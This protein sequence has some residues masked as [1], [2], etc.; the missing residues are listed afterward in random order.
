MIE[1]LRSILEEFL[2]ISDLR[3]RVGRLES[4][5]ELFA[6]QLEDLG[7]YK[8]MTKRELIE[9]RGTIKTIHK[10]LEK[11][12]DSKGHD[13]EFERAKALRKRLRNNLTRVENQLGVYK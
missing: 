7:G 1:K 6:S 3:G 12:I 13:E 9:V 11:I 4:K 8:E 2:G 10:I 5:F